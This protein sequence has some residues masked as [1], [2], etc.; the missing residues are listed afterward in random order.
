MLHNLDFGIY[1]QTGDCTIAPAGYKVGIKTKFDLF[2][3]VPMYLA[4]E[5]G[6]GRDLS[7][8][9]REYSSFG[10]GVQLWQK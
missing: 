3:V 4:V 7:S 5:Y 9:Y 2:E 6:N 1:G 8:Y 10:V